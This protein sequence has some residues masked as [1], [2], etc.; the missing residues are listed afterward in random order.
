MERDQLLLSITRCQALADA[1]SNPAHPCAKVVKTQCSEVYQVPEP[2][3]G[4]LETAPIIFISSNPGIHE[5]EYFPVDNWKEAEIAAFFDKRF[6]V[7]SGYTYQQPNSGAQYIKVY[8]ADGTPTKADHWN[9]YWSGVKNHAAAIMGRT[10]IPGTDYVLTEMVHCK[11]NSE[12]GVS[13]ALGYCSRKWMPSV[14]EMSGSVV[15]V[16]L[17]RPAQIAAAKLWQLDITKKVRFDVPICGRNRAVILLPHTNAWAKR[18]L[19]HHVFPG[20]LAKLRALM[21]NT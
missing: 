5:T 11:S 21:T 10:P 17:G 4:H 16:I 8:R 12:E 19:E 1:R 15:V 13:A 9:R 18:K 2:W 7:G 14:L 6:D 20:D 3:T